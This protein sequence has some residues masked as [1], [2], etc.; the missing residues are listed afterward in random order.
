MSNPRIPFHAGP[1][2]GG[3]TPPAD[4]KRLIAYV[5]LN[6]EHWRFDSPMPRKIIGAP[7][8]I[9][10]VPDVPNFSWVEYGM[11]RGLPRMVSL[12]QAL[13]IPA[14]ISFNASVIDAYPSAAELLA[15]TQWEF[16]GHGLHQQ[17]LHAAEDER[18]VIGGCLN[19]IERLSGTS[20]RGWL[21]PGLQE[22]MH[23]PDLLAELGIEY[24]CDWVVDDVP[25][26]LEAKPKPL[27][28]LP[29]S[30][31]LND[32]V[33]YAVERQPSPELHRR[34]VDTLQVFDSADESGEVKVLALPLHPHLMGVPHRFT[35]LRQMLDL[36]LER[37]DVIFWSGGDIC[38]WFQA[39]Q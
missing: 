18:A 16:I 12:L 17:S 9:E 6:V 7:H 31:E 13:E 14:T 1:P 19:A 35:Y 37:D 30:L 22:T 2:E 23:T 36:L 20:P 4:G 28:A 8:G 11:R 25:V 5:V 26:W 24:V 33:V 29:Y 3:L 39:Q 27:V 15:S 10:H 32:S 38:S 34:L 21:G